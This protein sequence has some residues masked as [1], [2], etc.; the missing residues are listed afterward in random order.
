LELDSIARTRCPLE[1][2]KL[3]VVVGKAGFVLSV[4]TVV[5]R[6]CTEV[7]AQGLFDGRPFFGQNHP[8]SETLLVYVA[9]KPLY[10]E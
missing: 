1:V 5:E 7:E 2:S 9:E 4:W 8:V 10:E 3:G 6:C